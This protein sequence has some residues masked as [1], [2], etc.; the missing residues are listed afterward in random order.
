MIQRVLVTGGSGFLGS[1]VVRALLGKNLDVAVLLRSQSLPE[2][3]QNLEKKLTIIQ[4]ELTQPENWLQTA[5]T[6]AP[7]A[8]IHMA[9]QGVAGKARN[10][11]AQKDN[12]AA[13]VTLANVAKKLGAQHFIGAGTQ[14]EYGPV[15]RLCSES[16]P[17]NPTTLYGEAK[18]EAKQ[19]TEVYCQENNMRFAWLRIFSTYGPGDHDYWLIPYLVREMLA[20][21]VPQLTACEQLWDYLHAHDAADAF[22]R[23]LQNEKASGIFNLGSGEAYP[24]ALTVKTIRDQI[25]PDLPLG[26][27]AI[28][29]QA[30]Q[31]MH[32][33]ADISKLTNATGWT[34]KIP[35]IDGLRETVAWY[36]KKYKQQNN[37]A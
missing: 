36:V 15:N 11:P 9:W 35:L 34:P 5:R 14:A 17:E 12:I 8:I 16:D 10:D 3:L 18:L 29:Y 23:V 37:A 33:Q 2:R 19:K 32:L 1:Y 13:T 20:A 25:N 6:F 28:P 22:V 31:V 21:R 30:D 27:G 24:L 4:G 26:I 7:E